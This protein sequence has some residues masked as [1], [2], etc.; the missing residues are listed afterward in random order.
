MTANEI[1]EKA[2]ENGVTSEC[3]CV[4]IGIDRWDE[5]MNGATRANNK[6]IERIL[7]NNGYLDKE[8]IKSYNPYNH[9]KTETHL[10]YVHSSIEHFF[11][12]N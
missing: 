7:I 12:I 4:G 8:E 5:L 1:Y 10:I 9:F 2:K 11:K 3:T 6:I